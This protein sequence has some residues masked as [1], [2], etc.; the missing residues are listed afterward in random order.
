MS[1]AYIFWLNLDNNP[2]PLF[3]LSVFRCF[4][5]SVKLSEFRT[6]PENGPRNDISRL[7]G[8]RDSQISNIYENAEAA[9]KE[10]RGA[11]F[12]TAVGR[13]GAEHEGRQADWRD[14]DVGAL[15]EY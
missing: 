15:R 9:A 13:P 14:G 4:G 8:G 11:P 2:Y 5:G 7:P 3:C 12:Q 6:A 1:P 10:V